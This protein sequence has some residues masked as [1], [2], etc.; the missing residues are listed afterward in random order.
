MDEWS[1]DISPFHAGARKGR[2]VF[3]WLNFPW[4]EARD[5]SAGSALAGDGETVKWKN[6]R[7]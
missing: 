3:A 2:L 6:D 1:D 5:T 7:L 4:E